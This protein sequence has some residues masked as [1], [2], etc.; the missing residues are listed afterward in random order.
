MLAW[1]IKSFLAVSSR[2]PLVNKQMACQNQIKVFAV[3][4][5]AQIF[6]Q[7]LHKLKTWEKP[8]I[9]AKYL[10]TLR[11]Q[12]VYSHGIKSS[13]CPL[14]GNCLGRSLTCCMLK[15]QFILWRKAQKVTQFF[16]LTASMTKTAREWHKKNTF[17]RGRKQNLRTVNLSFRRREARLP[18]DIQQIN[19]VSSS[20]EYNLCPTKLISKGD[21]NTTAFSVYE[22]SDLNQI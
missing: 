7:N 1:L 4:W 17:E 20:T 8:P 11:D 16:E 12:S 22:N 10:V 19:S 14:I 21:S 13:L 6:A 9:K 15:L 3:F 5:F 18:E 2:M